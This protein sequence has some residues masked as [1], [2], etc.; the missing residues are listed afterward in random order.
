MKANFLS[1]GFMYAEDVINGCEYLIEDIEALDRDCATV[2]SI[3]EQ[4]G[5]WDDGY[6]HFAKQKWILKSDKIPKNDPLYDRLVP[7]SDCLYAAYSEAAEVYFEKYP[8]AKVE[9]KSLENQISLLKYEESGYLPKHSDLGISTRIVTMILY[10]NDDYEGGEI[11]FPYLD[12]T[13]KP[14][15]GSAVFFPANFMTIHEVSEVTKGVRYVLPN[16]YHHAFEEKRVFS[17]GTA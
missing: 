8:Y 15:A 3:A 4:W 6:Q 5:N 10:L 11:S 16:W 12:I 2:D 9:C 1:P 13:L 14:K 17:D 7:I